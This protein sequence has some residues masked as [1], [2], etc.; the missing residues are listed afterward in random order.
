MA[1]GVMR[2][3]S[4]ARSDRLPEVPWSR[5]CSAMARAAAIKARRFRLMESSVS[6]SGVTQ[7][8]GGA[9]LT[10]RGRCYTILRDCF[11]SW[12]AG[13]ALLRNA[14]DCFAL[15]AMTGERAF[16]TVSWLS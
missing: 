1:E 10:G 12:L 6:C 5:P 8:Q 7:K 14:L 11:K 16:A 3:P 4:G 15:L 13:G 9:L 2:I